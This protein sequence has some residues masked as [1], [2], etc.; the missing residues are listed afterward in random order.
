MNWEDGLGAFAS[1]AQTDI[2][3]RS[4]V[5]GD[6]WLTSHNVK[7]VKGSDPG[8]TSDLWWAYNFDV[9]LHY[10]DVHG[11][12]S[13]PPEPH[14]ILVSANLPWSKLNDSSG[15]LYK[16]VHDPAN[17]L[18]PLLS[19]PGQNDTTSVYSF[20]AAAN[21]LTEVD[22]WLT[23][24]TPRIRAWANDL[25]GDGSDW[26]GSAASEFKAVLNAFANEFENLHVQLN[27]PSN[28]ANS[29]TSSRSQLLNATVALYNAYSAWRGGALAWPVNALDQVFKAVMGTAHVYLDKSDDGSVRGYTI[30]T[31][32]GDPQG[33]DFWD[34][35]QTAAKKLWTDNI[36]SMLDAPAGTALSAL[37]SSYT[38]T[39]Q[40]LPTALVPLQL[41]LPDSAKTTDPTSLLND[42]KLNTSLTQPDSDTSTNP[43]LKDSTVTS[44]TGADNPLNSLTSSGTGISSDSNPATDVSGSTADP[45]S[46]LGLG[47]SVTGTGTS[48]NASLPNGSSSLVSPGGTDQ[49]PLAVPAGSTVGD[50]GSVV[51]PDGKPVLDGAG[52]PISVPQG[53]TI[54]PTGTVM[55]ALGNPVSSSGS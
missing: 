50:D 33:N 46:A 37:D 39:T 23:G 52:N 7:M 10:S 40:V 13:D 9:I 15:P 26:Q 49:S 54:T 4:K 24:W 29:V 48:S 42:P 5:T 53:S 3:P 51:G 2:T 1:T 6:P 18:E 47:S 19:A 45:T 11:S 25:E 38:S 17:I 28:F 12:R 36:A 22:T 20:D 27:T 21:M 32:L 30:N 34:K 41:R 14:A 35:L 8:A 43:S 44:N 55:D 31:F 16:F